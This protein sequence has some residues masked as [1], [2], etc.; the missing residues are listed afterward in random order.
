MMPAPLSD[1]LITAG[2]AGP[3]LAYAAP[4]LTAL[5]SVAFTAPATKGHGLGRREAERWGPARFDPGSVAQPMLTDDWSVREFGTLRRE[6]L[7]GTVWPHPH[8]ADGR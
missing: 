2:G 8:L 3:F 7:V 5:V 4:C 6:V 1:L